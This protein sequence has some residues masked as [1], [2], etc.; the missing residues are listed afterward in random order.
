MFFYIETIIAF[1]AMLIPLLLAVAFFT[2]YERLILA[3]LQRRQGPNIVGF[4]GLFQPIADGLKLFVKESIVPKSSN[5]ML[6]I[7][8]PIFTFGLAIAG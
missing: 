5:G 4:Y 2:L 8:A 3:A 7:F 6:F 1:L